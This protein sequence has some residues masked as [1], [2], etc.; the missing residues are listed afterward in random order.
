MLV[1]D[2]VTRG[3]TVLSPQNSVRGDLASSDPLRL[4]AAGGGVS[5]RELRICAVAL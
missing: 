3:G 4:P 2:S 1:G 5:S